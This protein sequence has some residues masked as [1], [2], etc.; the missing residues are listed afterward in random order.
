MLAMKIVC[1]IKKKLTILD[2]STQKISE[3]NVVLLSIKVR[4]ILQVDEN[5]SEPL[6]KMYI[7]ITKKVKKNDKVYRKPGDIRTQ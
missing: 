3:C 4:L 6:R 7:K 1:F 2:V 5:G